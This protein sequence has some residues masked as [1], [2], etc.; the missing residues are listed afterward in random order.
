MKLKNKVALITGSSRGIGKQTAIAMAKEGANIVINYLNSKNEAEQLKEH[1]KNKYNVKVLTINADVSDEEEV[2]NMIEKIITVFGRI[3]ILVNNAAI[4]NDSLAFDKTKKTFMSVL[5][6][7]LV[8]PFLTAKYAS[9]YMKKQKYGKIINVASTNAIDTYYPES[10]D[11]DAS[12]AGLISLTHNL[13]KELAPLIT[14]NAVA[15][16][17]TNTDMNK[18]LNEEQITK[19]NNS[20]LLKRF[21][22]PLEIANVITFLATDDANYINDAVIRIDGG[23]NH[24]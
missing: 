19:A 4:D 5:E 7:N 10:L 17:W 24:E 15:P 22:D 8:G 3:D 13:A 9:F 1:I 16:G 11:Y 20:I 14:V 23:Y 2:K 6:T 18:E 21:A 12:K